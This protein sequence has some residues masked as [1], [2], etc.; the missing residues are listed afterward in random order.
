MVPIQNSSLRY[1]KWVSISDKISLVI[2]KFTYILFPKLAELKPYK[3][4]VLFNGHKTEMGIHSR[5]RLT[6]ASL[7]VLYVIEL[8]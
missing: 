7:L 5:A 2:Q 8:H 1:S 4:I 6:I 3:I